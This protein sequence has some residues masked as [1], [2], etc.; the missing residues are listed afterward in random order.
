MIWIKSVVSVERLKIY[1]SL[2]KIKQNLMDID[3]VVK[4]VTAQRI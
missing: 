1:Q 2:E 3:T 4:V